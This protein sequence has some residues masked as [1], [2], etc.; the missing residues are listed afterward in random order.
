M[1]KNKPHG[2]YPRSLHG[3]HRTYVREIKGDLHK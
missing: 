1:S 2:T 3:K